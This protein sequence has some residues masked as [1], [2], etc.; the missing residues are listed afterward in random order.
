MFRGVHH[1][2]RGVRQVLNPAEGHEQ[3][4]EGGDTQVLLEGQPH[5]QEATGEDIENETVRDTLMLCNG[6]FTL[7]T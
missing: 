2:G 3:E 6:R 5:P 1:V 7:G 4:E